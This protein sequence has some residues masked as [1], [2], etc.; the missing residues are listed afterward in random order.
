MRCFYAPTAFPNILKGA[1]RPLRVGSLATVE[2]TE[3]LGPDTN[4]P[5]RSD[6]PPEP[7]LS[8]VN[9]HDYASTRSLQL[10]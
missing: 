7:E 1:H 6:A 8:S 5:F 9:L 4:V 2:A 3:E 10:L